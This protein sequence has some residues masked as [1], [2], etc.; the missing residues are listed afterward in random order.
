MVP[1]RTLRRVLPRYPRVVVDEDAIV[2]INEDDE[3]IV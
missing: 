2:I 3:R 1:D